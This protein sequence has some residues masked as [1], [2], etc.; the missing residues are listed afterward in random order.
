MTR[1]A[2]PHAASGCNYPEG[3]CAN[4]CRQLDTLVVRQLATGPVYFSATNGVPRWV[5]KREDAEALSR[6]AAGGLAAA[7]TRLEGPH[8][9]TEPAQS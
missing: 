4:L 3:E 6:R 1:T 8:F 9:G 7:F 5:S 2:C